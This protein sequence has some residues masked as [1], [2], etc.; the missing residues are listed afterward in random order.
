MKYLD[1]K[2]DLTFKRVF[3]QHPH[4]LIS[5]LN[6]L[7][8]L[9][10]GRIVQSIEYLPAELA[11]ENPLQKHSIVDVRCKD[12]Q[13]RQFIVEMQMHWTKAFMQRV[14]FN[15]SKAYVTQLE[16]SYEYDKLEPVYTLSLVNDIFL[17]EKEEY[18]HHY[19]IVN[20]ADTE[21]RIEGLE[22]IFIELPKFKAKNL[23]EKRLQ[24][25]WLRF[26][27]EIDEK[28]QEV[29]KDLLKDRNISKALEHLRTSAFTEA[30]M[31]AYDRYWDSVR[32]LRT[33]QSGSFKSGISEGHAEGHAEGRAEGRAEGENIGR[34]KGERLKAYKTA[35][36][37]I[38]MNMPEKDIIKLTE[39]SKVDVTKLLKLFEKYGRDALRHMR[40]QND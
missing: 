31:N 30:E 12:N 11:P 40:E 6:A 26:L 18:Y 21:Q 10:E 14:L 9:E 1:P 33:L 2:S 22:F 32:T 20:I 15:A 27:T 38:E 37:A 19:Q 39:L 24:V 35:L 28:T 7:L 34:E 25:L 5:F 36:K 3:G 16:R 4:L 13:G 29:P 23:T 17:P 8:P